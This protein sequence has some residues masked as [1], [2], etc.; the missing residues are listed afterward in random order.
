M[1]V[2]VR[3]AR[4]R[5]AA[6]LH[7]KVRQLDLPAHGRPYQLRNSADVQRSLGAF[8]PAAVRIDDR[9]LEFPS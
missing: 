3:A 8:G 2:I 7:T 1:P 4:N 9:R 5:G 6:G